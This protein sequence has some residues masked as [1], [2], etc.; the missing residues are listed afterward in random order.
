MGICV[1]L[2]IIIL[3]GACHVEDCVVEIIAQKMKSLKILEVSGCAKITDK[4][5]LT[6]IAKMGNSISNLKLCETSITDETIKGLGLYCQSLQSLNI[7]FCKSHFTE[8]AFEFLATN[9]KS[10]SRFEASGC[11]SITNEAIYHILLHCE[12]LQNLS[13]HG[14]PQITKDMFSSIWLYGRNLS[15][16]EIT[17]TQ[18]THQDLAVVHQLCPDLKIVT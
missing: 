14:S 17:A 13:V 18:I 4:S 16:L 7:S 6:L 2:K 12:A 1:E 3:N 8:D 11:E 15:G 9:C 5:M 10:L